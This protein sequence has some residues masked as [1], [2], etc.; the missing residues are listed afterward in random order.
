[1]G[2]GHP[3]YWDAY[4]LCHSARQLQQFLKSGPQHSEVVEL[5][6]GFVVD[7]VGLEVGFEY[8]KVIWG[9]CCYLKNIYIYIS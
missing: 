6:L 1:M 7:S 4:L 5:S 9:F 3:K 8:W 2:W